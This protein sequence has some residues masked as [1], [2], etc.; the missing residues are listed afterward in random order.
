LISRIALIDNTT[1][2]F[3]FTRPVHTAAMRFQKCSEFND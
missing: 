3:A 2:V 1:G